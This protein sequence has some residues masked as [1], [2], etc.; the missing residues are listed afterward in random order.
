MLD[1]LNDS[2]QPLTITSI[3]LLSTTV[4][5]WWQQALLALLARPVAE[6]KV[7]SNIVPTLSSVSTTVQPPLTYDNQTL[8]ST[9][10]TRIEQSGTS[11]QKSIRTVVKNALKHKGSST[12]IPINQ[13]LLQWIRAKDA[14]ALYYCASNDNMEMT[15][16]IRAIEALG[17]LYNPNIEQWLTT[18]MTHE[19]SDIQKLAY[20][21]LRRWQRA[22]IR[23]QQKRPLAY[24]QDSSQK[25]NQGEGDSQ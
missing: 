16:R 8:L 20:K 10:L 2:R 18:L 1:W 15:V 11:T 4:S 24:S 22:M 14:D 9:L 17:Q 23:A 25:S 19:N 3:P 5:G 7:L 12:E 13:Q 6:D 21:V